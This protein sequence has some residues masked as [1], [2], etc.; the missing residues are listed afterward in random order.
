MV[1]LK[2]SVRTGLV[3]TAPAATSNG[4]LSGERPQ[5]SMNV[6]EA[7]TVRVRALSV[8]APNEPASPEAAALRGD[9]MRQSRT[10]RAVKVAVIASMLVGGV[11]GTAW[12]KTGAVS[13]PRSVVF[14]FGEQA[15]SGSS[16]YFAGYGNVKL[17]TDADNS[18]GGNSYGAQYY[19]KRAG[20][21]PDAQLLDFN[22]RY[23]QSAFQSSRFNTDSG[24]D[25][26]TRVA[27]SAV[28]S[29]PNDADGFVASR[30]GSLSC[31]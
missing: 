9:M 6:K 14:Y 16:D 31:P 21:I 18:G 5:S 10:S 23:N 28:P 2:A 30:T 29:A 22:I 17:C 13:N 15:G 25:Y 26:Q 4:H 12:A 24:N 19:R 8:T 11:G 20:A 1:R 27:W 7:F 3:V